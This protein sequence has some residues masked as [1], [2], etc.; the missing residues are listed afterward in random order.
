M[1]LETF[2]LALLSQALQAGLR[3]RSEAHWSSPPSSSY[4]ESHC[5]C[6]C[7][8]GTERDIGPFLIIGVTGVVCGFS[9]Y[10]CYASLKT[11]PTVAPSPRRKGHGIV[12]EP[13]SWPGAGRVL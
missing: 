7:I 8:C 10:W 9:V 5:H 2:A 4:S 12:N 3:H 11:P 1:R 6:T 13:L